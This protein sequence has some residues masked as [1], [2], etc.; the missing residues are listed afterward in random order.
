VE[1]SDGTGNRILS[2]SIFFNGGLGIDLGGNFAVTP[3]DPQ[4]PDT[5]PNRLQNYPEITSAKR[6]PDN[7]TTITGRLNSTPGSTFTLQFFSSPAADASGFGEGKTFLGEIQVTT[8]T[9]GDTGTFAF[10]TSQG[11]AP[12]GQFITATATNVA[13]GD[14]S[15]FSEAKPVESVVIPPDPG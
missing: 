14:T 8:N 15:E 11:A 9:R 2:N 1:I 3:N 4:D 7:T 6:F 13:T 12:V 10:T 5:G